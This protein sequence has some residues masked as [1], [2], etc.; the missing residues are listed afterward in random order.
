MQHVCLNSNEWH[1]VLGSLTRFNLHRDAVFFAVRCKG[2]APALARALRAACVD[3]ECWGLLP[4]STLVTLVVVAVL[5]VVVFA[6]ILSL[7]CKRR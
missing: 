5:V 6:L 4:F 3:Q 1:C 2:A 7:L